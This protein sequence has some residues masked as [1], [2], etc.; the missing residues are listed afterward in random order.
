M[1][2]LSLADEVISIIM[3]SWFFVYLIVGGG[4]SSLGSAAL[5]CVYALYFYLIYCGMFDDLSYKKSVEIALLIDGATALIMISILLLDKVASKH[6][7]ILAFAVS[8]HVVVLLSIK[9][10]S[11]GFFYN[12]YDELIITV[13]LLQI[14]VTFNGMAEGIRK[15]Q[16]HS[17]RDLNHSL[18]NSESLFP[19]KE[20]EARK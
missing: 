13:C 2:D 8:C 15:L 18:H 1:Y 17:G 9:G 7:M 11:Y 5:F 16:L 20:K 12:W 4:R 3:M 19:R 6:A 10:E 14:M